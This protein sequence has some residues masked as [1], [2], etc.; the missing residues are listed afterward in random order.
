MID[1]LLKLV[2]GQKLRLLPIS[3]DNIYEQIFSYYVVENKTYFN[4]ESFDFIDFDKREI[5]PRFTRYYIPVEYDD[6]IYFIKI[7]RKIKDMIDNT[8][9]EENLKPGDFLHCEVI[10]NVK[11]KQVNAMGQMLPS[12]DKSTIDV[13]YFSFIQNDRPKLD[14]DEYISVRNLYE[15]H[16]NK[17]IIENQPK[18]ISYLSDNGLL[19]DQYRYLLR[20]IK[21]NQF[22]EKKVNTT[23]TKLWN[24]VIK[25]VGETSY[26]NERIEDIG[27]L[28]EDKS[29]EEVHQ[30]MVDG[31]LFEV[32]LKDKV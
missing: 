7:G 2:D 20:G 31:Y 9:K 19:K 21:I 14:D 24:Q 10:L 3:A 25:M 5:V 29:G 26:E 8:M 28:E 17:L 11:I 15:K 22:R 4:H 18:T 30:F 23:K 6:E 12:Y 32:K 1:F 16:M 13:N 27:F